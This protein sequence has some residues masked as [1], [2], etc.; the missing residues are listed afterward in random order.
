M[1]PCV[2]WT[3]RNGTQRTSEIRPPTL[4]RYHFAIITTENT[5]GIFAVICS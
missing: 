2:L 1:P 5:K 4:G 3:P